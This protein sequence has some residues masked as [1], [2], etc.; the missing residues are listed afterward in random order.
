V[1][2]AVTES[3]P[4]GRWFGTYTGTGRGGTGTWTGSRRRYPA[5][6]HGLSALGGLAASEIRLVA[7]PRPGRTW[8][9]GG[10]TA[11]HPMAVE[12]LVRERQAELHRAARQADLRRAARAASRRG[13]ASRAGPR[14]V[15][16]WRRR[17]GWRLIE[18]GLRLVVERPPA[19]RT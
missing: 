3:D 19:A 4:L 1:W 12:L 5:T 10:L 18:L 6:V 2:S 13:A 11:Q 16:A 17:A 15:P 8:R 14:R 9:M 7:L